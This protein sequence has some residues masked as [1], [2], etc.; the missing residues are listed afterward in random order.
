MNYQ[1]YPGH[2]T[3]AMRQMKEDIKLIDSYEWILSKLR[4]IGYAEAAVVL[5]EFRI[6]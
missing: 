6:H 5:D 2:M 1:W 4:D 3:K